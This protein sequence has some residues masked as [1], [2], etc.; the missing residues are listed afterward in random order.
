MYLRREIGLPAQDGPIET[1]DDNGSRSVTRLGMNIQISDASKAG[2]IGDLADTFIVSLV[3]ILVRNT[4]YF[5][6][7]LG[8]IFVSPFSHF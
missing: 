4:F 7:G 6:R 5:E 3:V 1:D 8:L 2:L